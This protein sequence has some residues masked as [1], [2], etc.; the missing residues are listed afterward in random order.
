[1]P[2][3]PHSFR[4]VKHADRHIYLAAIVFFF[5]ITYLI[6]LL[7]NLFDRVVLLLCLLLSSKRAQLVSHTLVPRAG[8]H[9]HEN[10]NSI[11]H[12]PS[13]HE[14]HTHHH[15]PPQQQHHHAQQQ[16][17]LRAQTEPGMLYA[18]ANHLNEGY[19]GNGGGGGYGNDNLPSKPAGK[20]KKKA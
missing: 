12:L 11:S 20:K 13:I 1:M 16:G 18:S 7:W 17:M 15:Y 4:R 5:S 10:S 9:H 19:G 6:I 2:P 14:S 8:A 3:K